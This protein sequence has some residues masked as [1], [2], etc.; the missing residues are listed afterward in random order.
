MFVGGVGFHAEWVGGVG[1]VG[2]H[3]ELEGNRGAVVGIA[4]G[5]CCCCE[6]GG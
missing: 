3:A 5:S 2:F 4:A 6:A 1:G